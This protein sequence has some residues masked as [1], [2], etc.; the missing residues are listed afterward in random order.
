MKTALILP[1]NTRNSIAVLDWLAAN[2]PHVPV[3]LMAQ[4]TPCGAAMQIR[5][6]ARP[7]T[8]REYEKVQTRLFELGLDGYVQARKAAQ[9]Q[10]IPSFQLE[11]VFPEENQP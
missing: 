8:R 6:L 4:Y 7:I 10:Y 3:S 2:L 11:G 1:E 5:E 9:A